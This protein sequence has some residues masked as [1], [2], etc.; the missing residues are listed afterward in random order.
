LAF[1]SNTHGQ[2][3]VSIETSISHTK[4]CFSG[5]VITA[6]AVEKSM[7]NKIAI[8]EIIITNQKDENVAL[9]KGTVYRSSKD[10]FKK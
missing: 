4:K 7:T 8:Y 6:K 9:F 2:K 10:W 3:C 5:D 1:A